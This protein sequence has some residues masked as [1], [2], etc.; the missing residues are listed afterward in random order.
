M[1]FGRFYFCLTQDDFQ[2]FQFLEK[3]MKQKQKWINEKQIQTTFVTYMKKGNEWISIV[4]YM[5]AYGT[6]VWTHVKWLDSFGSNDMF[7]WMVIFLIVLD[8][9]AESFNTLL[10]KFIN[11]WNLIG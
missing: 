6:G 2:F 3:T 10:P 8:H 7:I 11:Q 9:W 4:E 1:A 5:M